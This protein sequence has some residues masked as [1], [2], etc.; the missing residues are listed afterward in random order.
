M[1]RCLIFWMVLGAL[2]GFAQKRIP[3]AGG[4]AAYQKTPLTAPPAGADTRSDS[5]DI[6]QTIIQLDYWVVLFGQN[7]SATVYFIKAG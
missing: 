4:C 6:W 1:R 7:K 3:P 5:V 2:S